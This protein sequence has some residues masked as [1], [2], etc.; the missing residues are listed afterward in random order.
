[1]HQC[2]KVYSMFMQASGPNIGT[3]MQASG[4]K[5]GTCGP[6]MDLKLNKVDLKLNKVGLATW[7][8]MSW[9]YFVVLLS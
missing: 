8:I 5:Q 6:K 9:L 2:V 3:I 1:M 7:N 4:P